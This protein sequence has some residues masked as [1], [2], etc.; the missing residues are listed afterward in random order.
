MG[1]FW[2]LIS[3]KNSRIDTMSSWQLFC[4]HH[5]LVAA[6]SDSYLVLTIGGSHVAGSE[7][8]SFLLWVIISED[9]R[10]AAHATQAATVL[11]WHL[12]RSPQFLFLFTL[13][14]FVCSLW[15]R[16]PSCVQNRRIVAI[17]DP[18][19]FLVLGTIKTLNLMADKCPQIHNHSL[20][21]GKSPETEEI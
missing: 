10:S 13:W 12:G 19:S 5:Y 9:F 20:L 15:R 1:L 8:V 17:N 14:I 4:P 21:H 3:I 16:L 18:C 6:E 7:T 11:R 2:T